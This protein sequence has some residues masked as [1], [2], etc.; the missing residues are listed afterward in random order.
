MNPVAV[1]TG[2][3]SGLG[4]HT[5]VLLAQNAFTV[6]ATMRDVSKKGALLSAAEDAGVSVPV[7]PLDVT[8]AVSIQAA[9]DG[10]IA[11]AGQI[12]VWINNAGAGFAKHP[13]WATEEEMHWVTDVNYFGVVRC[14]RAVLPHMRG[15]KA[16]RVLNVTS[17][18]GLVGQPFNALYC[19]AKFAVEGYTEALATLLPEHFGVHV[20]CVEPG[21]IATEFAASA[22]VATFGTAGLPDDEY[23]PI[24]QQYLAGFQRRAGT[25]GRNDAYQTPEEVAAVLLQVVQSEDPPVRVRTSQWGE[26]L[27]RYKTAADPDGTRQRADVIERFLHERL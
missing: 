11:E 3:S 6:Y 14:I 26:R 22:T 7:V 2:T 8:D 9:V 17:V 27:C 19:A 12:D 16:G 24:F 13:E 25:S 21:G 1:I 15:R 23:A 20:T 5:A 10:I 4:L 18:G